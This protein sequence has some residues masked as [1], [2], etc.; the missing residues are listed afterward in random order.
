MPEIGL[1]FLL[2]LW[3]ISVPHKD[4][5]SVSLNSSGCFFQGGSLSI[6]T[7]LSSL[8]PYSQLLAITVCTRQGSTHHISST[9]AICSFYLLPWL[10]RVISFIKR[11]CF[12]LVD[13]HFDRLYVSELKGRES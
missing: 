6:E 4:I 5:I 3:L 1:R 12:N 2:S 13:P 8:V 11:D 7:F 10:A 9:P